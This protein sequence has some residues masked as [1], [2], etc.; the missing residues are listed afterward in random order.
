M[1]TVRLMLTLSL[2]L[3]LKSRSI[4]FTLAFT[5]SPI[6]IPTFLDLPAGFSVG[7][8]KAD[9]VLELK[10]TVYGLQQAGL[11]WLETL[12]DYLLSAGFRQSM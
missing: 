6:D 1:N 11:N 2:L 10:K 4:D 9:Y 5:Q 12:R 8:Q 7:E 3:G